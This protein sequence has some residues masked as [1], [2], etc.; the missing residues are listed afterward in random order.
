MKALAEPV[1]ALVA[2]ARRPFDTRL[3]RVKQMAAPPKAVLRAIDKTFV[4][5]A[6]N[7]SD[8]PNAKRIWLESLIVSAKDE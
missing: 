7:S 6:D 5:Q 3:D 2:E 8:E 1:K 4:M